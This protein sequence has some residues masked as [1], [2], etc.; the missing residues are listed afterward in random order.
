MYINKRLNHIVKA[1]VKKTRR[2]GCHSWFRQNRTSLGSSQAERPITAERWD[3]RGHLQTTIIEF[4]NKQKSINL[5]L[6]I[7]RK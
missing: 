1:E 4:F 5:L 3:I 6:K 7:E 2:L